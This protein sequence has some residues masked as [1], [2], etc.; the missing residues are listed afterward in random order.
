MGEEEENEG[1]VW[2]SLGAVVENCYIHLSCDQNTS[3]GKGL[4]VTVVCWEI[5]LQFFSFVSLCHFSQI[6]VKLNNH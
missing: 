3:E 2:R 6:G 5:V 4:T 1:D